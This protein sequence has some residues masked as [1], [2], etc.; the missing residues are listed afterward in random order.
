MVPKIPH[1]REENRILLRSGRNT[2]VSSSAF[3]R[4]SS[5]LS[6]ISFRI[7]IILLVKLLLLLI[8]CQLLRKGESYVFVFRK[9]PILCIFLDYYRLKFI[10]SA[11]LAS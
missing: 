3:R 2:E 10:L 11:S 4:I 1:M 9:G 5:S 7:K 8:G 6:S